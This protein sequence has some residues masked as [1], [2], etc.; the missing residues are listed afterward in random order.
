[1]VGRNQNRNPNNKRKLFRGWFI[2]PQDSDNCT[3]A[4]PAPFAAK[5]GWL[6]DYLPRRLRVPDHGPEATQNMESIVA[7]IMD[8]DVIGLQSFADLYPDYDIGY[9]SYMTHLIAQGTVPSGS[10]GRILKSTKLLHGLRLDVELVKNSSNV[11]RIRAVI[12]RGNVTIAAK[13][14]ATSHTHQA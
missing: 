11:Q 9:Q 6:T 2:Q 13:T 7:S 12:R 1:M 5:Q 10:R 8:K 14:L 3:H 4:W